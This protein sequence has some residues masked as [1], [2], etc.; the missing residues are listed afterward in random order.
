MNETQALF[1][2]QAQGPSVIGIAPRA[3]T[4]TPAAR[5]LMPNRMQLELRPSNLESLL[6]QG[7]RATWYGKI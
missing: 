6:A 2:D 1:P 3:Q 5:V 4:Q 7:H